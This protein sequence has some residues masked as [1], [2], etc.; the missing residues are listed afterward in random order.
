[1]A[2]IQAGPAIKRIREVI[3]DSAGTLRTVPASRFGGEVPTGLDDESVLAKAAD[4]PRVETVITSIKPSTATPP[5]IGNVRLYDVVFKTKIT[6]LV[7]P[8]EQVSDDDRDAL[9]ASVAVDADV[10]GQALGYPGNLTTT[11]AGTATDIVSGL[12]VA[13]SADIAIRRQ[14]NE[15]GQP[16]ETTLTLLGR[17]ISRPATS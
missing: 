17:L 11:T 15:G 4:K 16:I 10:L 6:R 3:E 8:L 5:V 12:L 1:M 14:V 9:I 13:Q 7:T 2:Y